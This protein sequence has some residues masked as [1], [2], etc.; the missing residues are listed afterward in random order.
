MRV[1]LV[2]L[3]PSNRTTI[4]LSTRFDLKINQNHHFIYITQIENNVITIEITKIP[5]INEEVGPAMMKSSN[6]Y[7]AYS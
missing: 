2:R 7:I 1:D 6:K 4:I 5:D 3:N